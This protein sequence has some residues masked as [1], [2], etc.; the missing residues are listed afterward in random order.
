MQWD[1]PRSHCIVSLAIILSQ[2]KISE[3]IRSTKAYTN[4]Q[5]ISPNKTKPTPKLK[6]KNDPTTTLNYVNYNEKKLYVNYNEKKS[7]RY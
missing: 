1:T 4:Q 5:N 3:E 2:G 6:H 7:L